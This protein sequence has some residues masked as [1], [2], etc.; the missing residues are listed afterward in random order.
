MKL[1][2]LSDTHLGHPGW[3]GFGNRIWEKATAITQNEPVDVLL[4]CG[5]LCEPGQVPLKDALDLMSKVR[6]TVKLW[7]AGNNDIEWFMRKNQNLEDYPDWLGALASQ[8]GIELLDQKPVL[9]GDYAFVG[10]FGAYDFSLWRTPKIPCERFPNTL[11][12]LV[13]DAAKWH[14]KMGLSHGPLETFQLCQ[15][16]LWKHLKSIDPKYKIVVATH[17]VPSP[18]MVLYG[19]SPAYDHKNAWMGWDD[20]GKILK[21][22]N[23]IA[24][25]CGHTHRSCL[26]NQT[27][28]VMN[29]SGDYQ[30]HRIDLDGLA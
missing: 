23:V 29:V 5:D 26:I 14:R 16:R 6:A 30:P 2:A 24:H 13:L 12:D 8:Y 10:S 4:F 7:V 27:P 25:L 19:H 20:K 28:L 15:N 3:Q 11:K 17:T 1:L 18:D 21:H 22:P 9:L